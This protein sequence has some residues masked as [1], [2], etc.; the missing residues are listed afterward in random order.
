MKMVAALDSPSEEDKSKK[1]VVHWKDDLDAG[2]HDRID[3]CSIE[4]V[5]EQREVCKKKSSSSV[6]LTN[7]KKHHQEKTK[8]ARRTRLSRQELQQLMR[9]QQ[10]AIRHACE[11]ELQLL[12]KS[13]EV[14]QKRMR[15]VHRLQRMQRKLKSPGDAKKHLC[16]CRCGDDFVLPPVYQPSSHSSTSS[17]KKKRKPK[18]TC[19]VIDMTSSSDESSATMASPAEE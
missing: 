10:A 13:A 8:P 11:L 1:L 5:A 2:K 6:L 9:K 4:G 7:S 12:N 18:V 19:E 3:T 17:F 14:R 15:M 16:S